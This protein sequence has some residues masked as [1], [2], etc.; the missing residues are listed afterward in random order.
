MPMKG[1]GHLTVR[2]M[3]VEFREELV[4]RVRLTREETEAGT[5]AH[6]MPKSRKNG[7]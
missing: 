7:D 6:A 4:A 1:G 3:A 2:H 5:L